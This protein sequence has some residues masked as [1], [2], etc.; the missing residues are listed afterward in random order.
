M[1]YL[2]TNFRTLP[3]CSWELTN[4]NYFRIASF[5]PDM[6]GQWQF[7]FHFERS[8]INHLVAEIEKKIFFLKTVNQ[9]GFECTRMFC[10]ISEATPCPALQL[11][12]HWCLRSMLP[13]DPGL[14]L[15]VLCV[16][17]AAGAYMVCSS[18]RVSSMPFGLVP[19]WL[20]F[21]AQVIKDGWN[22]LKC[23]STLISSTA[24]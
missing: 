7:F 3:V 2:Q 18:K 5:F 23:P 8:L 22:S 14:P 19:A 21:I 1:S 11:H 9:H 20:H 13:D 6:L 16:L 15:D 4:D 24:A 12:G 10:F 17:L